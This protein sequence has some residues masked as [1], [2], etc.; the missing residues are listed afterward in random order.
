[1][2]N[3]NRNQ[4]ENKQ[5]AIQEHDSDTKQQI[6]ALNKLDNILLSYVNSI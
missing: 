1:M 4:T 3:I 5:N 6:K 2:S